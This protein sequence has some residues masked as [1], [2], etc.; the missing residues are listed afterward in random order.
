MITPNLLEAQ[1][2]V[3]AIK[4][5]RRLQPYF[6]E[7]RV[8]IVPGLDCMLVHVYWPAGHFASLADAFVQRFNAQV[9]LNRADGDTTNQPDWQDFAWRTGSVNWICLSAMILAQLTLRMLLTLQ[10]LPSS[11][12]R[13]TGAGPRLT[14]YAIPSYDFQLSAVLAAIGNARLTIAACAGSVLM[15]SFKLPRTYLR[16]E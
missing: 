5:T 10:A 16:E 4:T 8:Q 12:R 13:T 1:L 9:I 11:A 14:K 3:C 15:W 6:A 7:C 2:L